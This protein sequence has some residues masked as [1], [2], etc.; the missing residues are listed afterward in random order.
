MNLT[1]KEEKVIYYLDLNVRMPITKLSKIIKI[2]RNTL[3]YNIKKLTQEGIIIGYYIHPIY[4][5]FDKIYL[6]YYIKI[7]KN[8]K[9]FNLKEFY[10]HDQIIWIGKTSGRWDYI[11]T[12]KINN[13]Y[14]IKNIIKIIDK[15][16]EIKDKE[17]TIVEK[18]ITTN[19]KWT[20]IK[21][22]KKI[23][24]GDIL[25]KKI[26]IDKIESKIIKKLEENP[27]IGILELSKEINISPETIRKKFKRIN[28]LIDYK[29]RINYRKIGFNYYHI[30]INLSNKEKKEEIMNYLINNNTC[31]AVLE[32][33]GK[34]DVQAEIIIRKYDELLNILS[35]LNKKFS[36][37][38]EDVENVF[39]IE[40]TNVK[41]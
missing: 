6:K 2:N 16:F 1:K 3:E 13:N 40:D 41:L 39:I 32:Q 34:Y 28:K 23:I 17:M 5:I 22:I 31:I 24:K 12:I 20:H 11:F 18:G 25:T 14:E 9:L 35:E 26:E 36:E 7:K 29:V 30:L 4:N 8:I 33:I 37:N 10:N 38:I 19:E 21:D 15:Y 27:K